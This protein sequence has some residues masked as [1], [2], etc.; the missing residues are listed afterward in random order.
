MSNMFLERTTMHPISKKECANWP[1]Q[2]TFAKSIFK[3]KVRPAG[4]T[5]T[6][7]D[8]ARGVAE[9][10]RPRDDGDRATTATAGTTGLGL[11]PCL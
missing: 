11:P 5:A 2:D 7:G 8:D 1:K 9:G 3:I 6:A 10:Q 4:T